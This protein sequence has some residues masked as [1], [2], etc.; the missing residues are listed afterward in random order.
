[1]HWMA[2]GVQ[3]RRPDRP[4]RERDDRAMWKP[5]SVGHRDGLI[6]GKRPNGPRNEAAAG[7]SDRVKNS[8]RRILLNLGQLLVRSSNGDGLR[9]V[10]GLR[11][12]VEM[13]GRRN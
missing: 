5:S 4:M 6:G 1:M 8:L 7:G 11:R 3:M 2:H 12:V 10:E 13:V 9:R